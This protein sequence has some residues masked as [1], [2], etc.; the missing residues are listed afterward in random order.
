MLLQLTYP[1]DPRHPSHLLHKIVDARPDARG[2][3]FGQTVP[4]TRATDPIPLYR[5]FWTR[6]PS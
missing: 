5:N 4:C 3:F 2:Y 1:L 6:F